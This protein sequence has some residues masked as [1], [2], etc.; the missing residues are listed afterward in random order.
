MV[1]G[2]GTAERW[3][4]ALRA[5]DRTRT[6]GTFLLFITPAKAFWIALN[7]GRL[8]PEVTLVVRFP[9]V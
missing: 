1:K 4:P 6:A 9:L 5:G 2:A 3:L 7:R 8:D